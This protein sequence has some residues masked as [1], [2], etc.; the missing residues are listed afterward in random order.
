MITAFKGGYLFSGSIGSGIVVARLPDGSWSAPSVIAMISGGF[1]WQGGIE[2]TDYVIV[3]H[4]KQALETFSR[5]GI[6]A[7]GLNLSIALGPFGRNLAAGGSASMAG[8]APIYAYSLT[9][10][11]FVGLSLEG[12]VLVERRGE[13]NR[14]YQV[15]GAA[16]AHHLLEGRV[17][18]PA[19]ADRLMEVLNSPAFSSASVAPVASE[20]PAA[21]LPVVEQREQPELVART[22][23]EA[24]LADASGAAAPV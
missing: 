10:G 19:V 8:V 12:S 21:D 4:N 17:A 2:L 22:S 6:L 3:L 23:T 16:S 7:L 1:G 18:P 11:I 14:F 9:R 20:A 15:G 13:N 5:S 24:Q